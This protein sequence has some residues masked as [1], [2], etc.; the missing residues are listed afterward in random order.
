MSVEIIKSLHNLGI[1]NIELEQLTDGLNYFKE[2]YE[3][4]K[5]IEKTDP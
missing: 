1:I 4:I 2:A 5:N 3:V